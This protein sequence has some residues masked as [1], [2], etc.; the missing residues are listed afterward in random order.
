MHAENTPE[1]NLHVGEMITFRPRILA[2][3]CPH[4]TVKIDKPLMF[5]FEAPPAA[6][7]RQTPI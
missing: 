4:V 1:S 3:A 6:S 7:Q 2:A 5:K